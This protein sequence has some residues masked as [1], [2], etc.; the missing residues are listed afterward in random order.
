MMQDRQIMDRLNF[1]LKKEI[2]FQ[3]KELKKRWC[4]DIHH[5]MVLGSGRG[6]FFSQVQK[7]LLALSGFNAKVKFTTQVLCT[8]TGG[9][10]GCFACMLLHGLGKYGT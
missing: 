2:T 6:G 1:F 4:A 8:L 5:F 3:T 7:S 10:L 9:W